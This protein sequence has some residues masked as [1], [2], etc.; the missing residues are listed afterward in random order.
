MLDFVLVFVFVNFQAGVESKKRKRCK[1][2]VS[3]FNSLNSDI[4]LI[5]II[6]SYISLLKCTR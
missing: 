6:A 2:I 4:K 5:M 3:C 1:Q